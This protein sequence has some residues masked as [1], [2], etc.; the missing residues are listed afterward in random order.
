MRGTSPNELEGDPH[1]HTCLVPYVNPDS[2]PP[3]IQEKL[4]VLPFRRNILLTLAHSHG[5]F[6]HISGLLG[7]CFDG[8]QRSI[9]V[10][11]W[12][13]IVLR[14]GTV[15]QAKYEIDVN[16]PVAEVFGFP[17]EKFN[18]IG[19]SIEEVMKGRGPWS[20]RDRVILRMTEEQLS[21]YDNKPETIEDALK[22][23]SVGDVVEILLIIGVYAMLARVIKGLKVD[24]DE[25]ILDLKKMIKTAITG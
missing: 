12:Q 3:N 5:L 21:T 11:E 14:V 19:C 7:A 1:R 22:L 9:P 17:Q 2:A 10:H 8:N 13:L 4:K 16:K 15:L 23:L 25:P 6:P 24:E 20:N 18:A